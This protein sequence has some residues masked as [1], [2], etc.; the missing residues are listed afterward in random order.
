MLIF[1]QVCQDTGHLNE[2]VIGKPNLSSHMLLE[3]GGCRL[4]HFVI[5][6]SDYMYLAWKHLPHIIILNFIFPVFDTALKVCCLCRADLNSASCLQSV[7]P[8]CPCTGARCV[9]LSW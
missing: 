7:M 5:L 1:G 2:L 6:D 8:L 3:M 4:I 9:N